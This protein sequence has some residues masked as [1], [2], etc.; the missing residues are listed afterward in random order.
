MSLKQLLFA[1][2]LAAQ[3]LGVAFLSLCGYWVGKFG[4][5]FGWD[6]SHPSTVFNYH[7]FFMALGLIFLNGNGK[8]V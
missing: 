4:G 8:R 2:A 7:P 1:G 6:K 5:G 3:V